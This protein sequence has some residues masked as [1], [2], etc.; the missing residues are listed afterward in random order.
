MDHLEQPDCRVEATV[1]EPLACA[2]LILKD[3]YCRLQATGHAAK[4]CDLY[5]AAQSPQHW[6]FV[7]AVA[8]ASP[9]PVRQS[10]PYLR[11]AARAFV[12]AVRFKPRPAQ[13]AQRGHYS[14]SA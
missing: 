2:A 11:I 8:N 4:H 7:T 6:T 5:Y 3:I 10:P 12:G 9:A 13:I 1:F 14:V